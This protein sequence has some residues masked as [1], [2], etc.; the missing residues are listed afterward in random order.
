MDNETAILQKARTAHPIALAL[1]LSETKLSSMIIRKGRPAL[2]TPDVSDTEDDKKEDFGRTQSYEQPL[3]P[4]S[5][6]EVEL[7]ADD[8]Q[9]PKSV[10]SRYEKYI[11]VTLGGLCGFWSSISSPIYVPVLTEIQ[12]DFKITEAQVNVTIV[13]YSIF[14]GVGPL[15]FS[16]LADSVGRRPIIL[17]CL[18]LY[19]VA[20]CVLAVNQSYAGLVI[21]R[22]IQAF[23]VSPT[24]SL[25]SGIAS[26]ITSR[27][28][29]ASFIGLTTGLALLGQ[30][31]GAFIGGMISS[32]F[33]WRAIFYFLAISAGVTFVIIF[34]FLPET[35]AAIVGPSA[36]HL[37][38]KFRCV[39]VAPIMKTNHFASRMHQTDLEKGKRASNKPVPAKKFH[40]FK[41]LRTLTHRRAYL[42]LI[43]A[44]LCYA[45]W[46]MM[47]TTLSHALDSDYG[48]SMNGVALAYIPS[49][50]GGLL[51]S[52]S[53]GE[54]LDLSYKR[55]LQRSHVQH[56]RFSV[57]R[58]RLIVSVLP[59]V[60][61]VGASLLFAW[62]LQYHRLVILVLISSFLIAFGAM[63]WLTISSTVV[64]D[65][66]PTEASGAC[67][68]V[69]LT[70]CWCAALFVGV[71]T[72]M[73]TMGSGWC[74]TLM[75]CL[76]AVSSLCVVYIFLEE[77][78]Q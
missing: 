18:L 61:C 70:R 35:G 55:Y 67:A 10:F 39:T 54:M 23:S 6:S 62:S 49:G 72:Y 9:K 19:V 11:I 56:M 66:N 68:C 31:C 42:T 48:F 29:R 74:Y 34:V 7:L 45:L 73:E 40:P 1:M 33:G 30:A 77:G 5:G 46:L 60:L 25:G 3:T 26:D 63:N 13:V 47:L 69:N 8:D 52:I 57:L 43:P 51:G 71:L 36:K 17:V 64:V 65:M 76:C 15:V 24:I 37:P 2:D 59:S 41:P 16:N 14:Q 12:K 20:N 38:T 44:S 50:L 4:D 58:S 22:C 75:A 28:E 27:A 21:L 78:K 32:A 53:I